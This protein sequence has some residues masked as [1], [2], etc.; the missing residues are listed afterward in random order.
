ILAVLATGSPNW[1]AEQR[2][3]AAGD[4]AERGLALVRARGKVPGAP[5]ERRFLV[6]ALQSY[7]FN[8]WLADRITDGLLHDVVAGDLLQKRASG[9]TFVSTEPD[10]DRARVAAGEIVVTG[11]MFGSAMRGP[12]DGTPAH[13]REAKILDAFSLGPADFHPLRQIAEGTRRQATILPGD[14]AVEVVGDAPD[15]IRVTFTLPAGAYATAVMRELQKLGE[16]E[17]GP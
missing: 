12:P 11:P 1:Y 5:R 4:N 7:F 9:G 8:R 3:G 13:A 16:T 10:V 15:A 17:T 6:S 14:P 2:F